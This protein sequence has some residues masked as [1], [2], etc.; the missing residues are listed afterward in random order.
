MRQAS[1]LPT[2]ALA[3]LS[4]SVTLRQ[5]QQPNTLRGEGHSR[6]RTRNTNEETFVNVL[7]PQE[8]QEPVG[9][10]LERGRLQPSMPKGSFCRMPET[11]AWNFSMH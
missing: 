5:I 2:L 9:N 10:L 4:L 6:P 3:S 11:T 8:N 1:V 7:I